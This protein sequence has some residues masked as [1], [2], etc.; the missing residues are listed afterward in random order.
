LTQQ[1]PP[2]IC[3]LKKPPY[4]W[5]RI[6]DNV[7]ANNADAVIGLGK[8][9]KD[10]TDGLDAIVPN[11]EFAF[12][13]GLYSQGYKDS[14]A[15]II[16]GEKLLRAGT[17]GVEHAVTDIVSTPVGAVFGAAAAGITSPT[18]LFATIPGGVGFVAGEIASTV[19]GNRLWDQY[20]EDIFFPGI[21]SIFWP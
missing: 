6:P 5:P 19:L 11:P 8:M 20:N 7:A 1:A 10:G 17:V 3:T 9:I 21:H 15:D 14:F 2:P 18:G 16:L 12:F 4:T 13:V